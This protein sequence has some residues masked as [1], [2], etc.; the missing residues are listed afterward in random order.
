MVKFRNA[1]G[2]AAVSLLGVVPATSQA[3]ILT[4]LFTSDHCT[5]G[6]LTGQ[7]NGGSVTITDVSSG[8][9]SVAVS[10]ANGNQFVNTGFDA[11]FGFQLAGV[12]SITYSAIVPAANYS[13]PGGNPQAAQTLMMDGIGDFNHGLEGI[14]SGG[15]DPLGSSL[16][17]TIAAAG[18]TTG[19]FIQNGNGQFFGADI[20]SGSTGKTGGIDVSEGPS[21]DVPEP[22]PLALLAIGLLALV[23]IRRRLMS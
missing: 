23:G 11:S 13:I 17:F 2:I 14:G 21:H 10:L 12:G 15:S 6:C 3:D 20:L 7:T 18:L 19:S 22:A 1:L 8:V 5:G 9:V 16:S 4:F